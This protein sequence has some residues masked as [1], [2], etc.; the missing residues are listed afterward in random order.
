MRE[1]IDL[2]R[3]LGEALL[4]VLRAELAALQEDLSRSGRQL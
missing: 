2:F 3:S 1:W 4:E